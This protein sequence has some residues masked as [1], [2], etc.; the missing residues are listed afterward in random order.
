MTK[1]VKSF[2]FL[3]KVNY[4]KNKKDAVHT[5]YTR[6]LKIKNFLKIFK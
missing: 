3:K 6:K 4:Y 1:C 2:D 5:R